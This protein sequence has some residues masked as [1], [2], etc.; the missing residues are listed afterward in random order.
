[1]NMEGRGTGAANHIRLNLRDIPSVELDGLSQFTAEAFVEQTDAS[2]N[3]NIN[4][5]GSPDSGN[6]TG[7]F[8]LAISGQT[9]HGRMFVGSQRYPLPTAPGSL[10]D[11]TGAMQLNTVHHV[12]LTYDGTMIRL[13]RDGSIVAF[14]KASGPMH[15]QPYEDVMLGYDAGSLENGGSTN[16]LVGAVDSVRLSDIA[17]Y[18]ATCQPAPAPCFSPPTNKLANDAHTLALLNF[19]TQPSAFTIVDTRDGPFWLPVKRQFDTSG[20]GL[21]GPAGARV[22]DFTVV[23]GSGIVGWATEQTHVHQVDCIGCDLGISMFGWNWESQLDDVLVSACATRGRFGAYAYNTNGNGNNNLRLFG[24]VYPFVVQGGAEQVVTNVQ[25]YAGPATVNAVHAWQSANV[26][27]G[28][29][30]DA[31]NAG[32]PWLGAIAIDFPWSK[33]QLQGSTLGNAGAGIPITLT[34][35]PSPDGGARGPGLLVEGT[36]FTGSSGAPEIVHIA[37]A[38]VDPNIIV[39][40]TRDSNVRWSDDLSLVSVTTDPGTVPNPMQIPADDPVP[41]VMAG[42]VPASNIFDITAYGAKSGDGSDSSDSIQRAIK[43]ACAK[44]SS[45]VFIPVGTFQIA[46]PLLVNCPGLTISGAGRASA[47]SWGQPFPAFVLNPAG[48]TGVDLVPGLLPFSDGSTGNAM[49][50]DGASEWIDL[51][52]ALSVELDGLGAFTAEAFVKPT[53]APTGYGGIVQSYGCLGTA[54]TLPGCTSAFS[55]GMNGANLVGS[56]T[57]NGTSYPLQGPALSSGAVHHV[58]LRYDGATIG[59]LL[60]GNQ[61]ASRVNVSGHLT[62]PLH[63]DVTIGPRT[64]GFDAAVQDPAM[65]GIIDSVRLSNVARATCPL[66]STKLTADSNTL[67]LANFEA[68]PSGTTRVTTDEGLHTDYLVVRRTAEP[69]DGGMAEGTLTGVTFRDLTV[70]SAVFGMNATGTHFLNYYTN[71]NDQGIVLDGTSANSVFDNLELH[72]GGRGRFGLVV[73]NGDGSVYHNVSSQYGKMPL[74]V[75]GGANQTFTHTFV[76]ADP[77]TSVWGSIFLHSGDT[78]EGLFYDNEQPMP[79]GKGDLLVIDPIAPFQ[80]F[81]GEIDLSPYTMGMVPITLDGGKGLLLE[82]S[83]LDFT[84][85]SPELIDVVT[86]PTSGSVIALGIVAKS[87][88]GSSPDS[89]APLSNWAGVQ[90]IGN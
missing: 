10:T 56:L 30:V 71:A 86:P 55:L 13:F 59:L 79:A 83:S 65:P 69:G 38:Q 17:R 52:D 70:G 46:K 73:V 8:S 62:H 29:L 14:V 76:A 63:E 68:A 28:L 80:L 33:P 18:G 16:S 20:N 7:A 77:A 42:L 36:S 54:P 81:K 87:S 48:M 84:S 53:T 23:G 44:G 35:P 19:A 57:V 3:D 22:H 4:I 89:T 34:G 61:V 43:E 1:M 85:S 2:A 9:L 12:A 11:S 51:R 88:D 78:M 49:Q 25:I 60:D 50:T 64:V 40:S 27:N 58:C 41:P 21:D 45:T 5:L 72:A 90:S 6:G 24:Q 15:Q 82:G 67:I 75:Y 74:V 31:T 32:A 39:A 26:F 47:V 37:Q 66:P